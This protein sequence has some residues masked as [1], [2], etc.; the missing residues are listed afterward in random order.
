MEELS[1]I[2]SNATIFV[3]DMSLLESAAQISVAEGESRSDMT[4]IYDKHISS[5]TGDGYFEIY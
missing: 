5:T 2:S 4:E 1:V 3:I